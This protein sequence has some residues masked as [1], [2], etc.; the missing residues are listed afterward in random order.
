M[1][2][3]SYAEIPKKMFKILG[4]TGTLEEMSSYEKKI[5]KEEYNVKKFTYTPSMYRKKQS[6]IFN[7]YKDLF[8]E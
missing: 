4:V 1:G 2:N 6:E 3:F 8:I 5:I 7:E